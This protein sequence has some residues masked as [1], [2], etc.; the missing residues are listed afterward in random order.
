LIEGLD[1]QEREAVY[2]KLRTLYPESLWVLGLERQGARAQVNRLAVNREIAQRF[3]NQ[4]PANFVMWAQAAWELGD[5]AEAKEALTTGLEVFPPDAYPYGE[6][7]MTPEI[8]QDWIDT[9][10][11][12][13]AQIE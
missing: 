6:R 3:P 2:G 4:H 5:L 9:A 13:L 1:V 10:Y 11:A 12:M 7:R 8:Y